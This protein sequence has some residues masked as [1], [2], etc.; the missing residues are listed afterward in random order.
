ARFDFQWNDQFA[1][2]LDPERAAAYHDATMPSKDGKAAH[3][4][5]MCGP[6]FCAMETTR[7]VRE[8][9]CP[10]QSV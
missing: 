8:N 10:S 2:A 4:C 7:K 1:L 3:F 6:K 5:S 9:A